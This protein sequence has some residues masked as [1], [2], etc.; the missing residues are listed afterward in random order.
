[1]PSTG[2]FAF[3]GGAAS[4]RV[5]GGRREALA[6][7][8]AHRPA[9]ESR[10]R[11]Q[12]LAPAGPERQAHL[13]LLAAGL[14]AK[15]RERRAARHPAAGLGEHARDAPA[16]GRAQILHEDG[17]EDDARDA[18][19]GRGEAGGEPRGRTGRVDRRRDAGRHL[20]CAAE[21]R[22][23][24]ALV[25]PQAG[26][27]RD[28]PVGRAG[29]EGQRVA[30]GALDHAAATP[31]GR[32][33]VREHIDQTNRRRAVAPPRVPLLVAVVVPAQVQPRARAELEQA[34][35]ERGLTRDEQEA[36][37]ERGRAP[38][39]VGLTRA[40]DERTQRVAVL[41]ERVAERRPGALEPR[42]AARRRV[43]AGGGPPPPPRPHTGPGAPRGAA[44]RPGT[45]RPPRAPRG[46]PPTG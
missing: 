3:A 38:H 28:L 16:I 42:L 32:E 2:V 22:G 7:D 36:A 8:P 17:V 26:E 23:A 25:G 24:L 46:G 41:L 14:H 40:M 19:G 37:E 45:P 9:V 29:V 30:A 13:G 27:E 4:P 35:R 31:A 39:L 20:E 15:P 10:A 33:A 1:M 6:R 5:G 11:D 34:E 43:V 44:A 12:A 18:S 21:K